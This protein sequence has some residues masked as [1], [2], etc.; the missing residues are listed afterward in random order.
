MDAD[1]P[2]SYL[3]GRILRSV[4]ALAIRIA[5]SGV[6]EFADQDLYSQLI[7]AENDLAGDTPLAQVAVDALLK[8]LPENVELEAL[9]SQLEFDFEISAGTE[10]GLFLRA[11]ITPLNDTAEPG[12]FAV[13][14]YDVTAQRLGEQALS[15]KNSTLELL[16]KCA[17]RANQVNDFKHALVDCMEIICSYKNWL[18]DGWLVAHAFLVDEQDPEQL[19]SSDIWICQ[20]RDTI[21]PFIELTGNTNLR[22][23]V[24]IPGKVLET[25][26]AIWHGKSSSYPKLP[27]AA[28]ADE[29]GLISLVAIP[30][31][32]GERTVAILEFFADDER[33]PNAQLLQVLVSIGAQLG[34]VYDREFANRQLKHL[35]N[36]DALTGLVAMHV[37]RDRI[38]L[39]IA[40]AKRN[41]V[42]AAVLFIDL[43]G[44]KQVNDRYGH[45]T[46]DKLLCRVADTIT[47]YVREVDTVARFGGD[48]FLVVLSDL[49]TAEGA[50]R[51]ATNIL[52]AINKPVKIGNEEIQIGASIGISLYREGSIP[53]DDLIRQADDAMYEA[54]RAGK[55]CF[56]MHE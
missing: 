27:R 16:L 50:N 24:G 1:N 6:C 43:D 26:K 54:K 47:R 37:A 44:F 38:E 33:P 46:G 36:H 11:R 15:R 9:G 42:I 2:E 51:V 30:V 18:Y 23:G 12:G 4:S 40:W 3:L 5:P 20:D 52:D 53:V 19:V 34:S 29:C 25:G 10:N 7:D 39:A 22:S 56:L 21:E 55:N 35:A 17:N 41:N 48:E 8:R 32:A 13:F 28:V 31:R 49:Y 14:C 45:D